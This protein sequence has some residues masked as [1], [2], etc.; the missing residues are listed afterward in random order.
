MLVF[1]TVFANE[2]GLEKRQSRDIEALCLEKERLRYILSRHRTSTPCSVSSL[3]H[4][5]LA[6]RLQAAG[7]SGKK[8]PKGLPPYSDAPG[9]SALEGEAGGIA[10]T[11]HLGHTAS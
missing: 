11:T 3:S 2:N 7:T 10:S 9:I 6:V 1:G 4:F 5:N 8:Q